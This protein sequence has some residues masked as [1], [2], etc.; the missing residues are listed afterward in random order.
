M[1]FTE[2]FNPD[3]AKSHLNFTSVNLIVSPSLALTRV[4]ETL[5]G[6]KSQNSEENWQFYG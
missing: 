3:N 4:S 1:R 6:I 5:S 2:K